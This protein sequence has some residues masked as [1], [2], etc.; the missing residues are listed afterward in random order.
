MIFMKVI[1]LGERYLILYVHAYWLHLYSKVSSKVRVNK[2]LIYF[3]NRYLDYKSG[4][5]KE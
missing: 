3:K 1:R 2:K 4:L 5:W